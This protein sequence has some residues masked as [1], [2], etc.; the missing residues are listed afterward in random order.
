MGGYS[1]TLFYFGD[2][3]GCFVAGLSKEER[4]KREAEA[5]AKLEDEIKLAYEEKTANVE[6]ENS[7][8]KSQLAE[9]MSMIKE[10]KATKDESIDKNTEDI[11]SNE[12]DYVSQ[13]IDLNTRITVT[14]MTTGGVNLKTGSDGLAKHF[15]LEKLGQTIPIVYE[16]LI[17]CI[18]TDRWLFED[19]LVYINNA[20]AVEEQ[21][22]EEYYKKFLT[23]DKISNILDFDIPTIRRMVSNT[24]K[25]IQEA[26][27]TVV[28]VKINKNETIDM[29]KVDVIGKSCN[30]QIDIR[31]LA[32]KLR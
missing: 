31:D 13:D 14:S 3:G 1:P 32:N 18:N 10:L 29:N 23:P 8:L 22:L 19:G 24:T 17:N 6:K 2:N 27:V 5:K 11:T 26:I 4:E 16:H 9:L 20:K 25:A 28:A 30:P 21:Y 15:R 12:S 7:E